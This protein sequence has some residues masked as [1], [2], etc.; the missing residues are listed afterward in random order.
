M[1]AVV[2]LLSSCHEASK[3]LK[4]YDVL[5][6]RD[7]HERMPQGEE[8]DWV[9]FAELLV[10]SGTLRVSDPIFFRDLPPSPAF[11]VERGTYRALVKVM[12]YS[13]KRRV[14]RL[15][16][17]RGDSCS[18]GAHLADVGVDFG[19]VGIFDPALLEAAAEKV[20][21]LGPTDM[22]PD[23]N[24]IEEYGVARIEGAE[25]AVMAV[26]CSGFGDGGYPI[27][28]L[29]SAGRRV[30]LEVVFIGPEVLAP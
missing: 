9:F 30:G 5:T 8:T 7:L 28:E 24:S 13:D 10:H 6:Q 4:E 22:L 12:T 20:D 14:S 11:E 17:I 29:V 25:D 21:E 19:Q 27:H 16:V 15:R 2:L 1:A 26:A 3:S 23:L 18:L